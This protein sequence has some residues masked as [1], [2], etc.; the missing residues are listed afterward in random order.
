MK[1]LYYDDACESESRKYC[2]I[3]PAEHA[4]FQADLKDQRH[5]G[6]RGGNSFPN[7]QRPDTEGNCPEGFAKC[8]E[9]TSIEN[10]I[11]YDVNGGKD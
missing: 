9:Q 5:C 7:A 4:V 11:C 3:V 10:T 2:R 8:S 1:Y 6:Y